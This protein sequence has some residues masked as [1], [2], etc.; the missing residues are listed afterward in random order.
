MSAL[1]DTPLSLVRFLY[2]K[3]VRNDR[4]IGMRSW[5]SREN[6]G[7]T[8]IYA[9]KMRFILRFFQKEVMYFIKNIDCVIISNSESH[10]NRRI[11]LYCFS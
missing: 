8:A 10:S 9:N 1:K 3:I 5:R 7:Y 4:L 6:D 2:E 11:L